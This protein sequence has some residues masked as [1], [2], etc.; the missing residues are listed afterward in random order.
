MSVTP[1]ARVGRRWP[2]SVRSHRTRAA[3]GASRVPGSRYS[4]RGRLSCQNLPLP[5]RARSALASQMIV[6]APCSG[7]RWT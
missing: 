6:S 2:D 4:P 5:S 3:A 1:G 7:V